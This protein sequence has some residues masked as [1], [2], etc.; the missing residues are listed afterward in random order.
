MTPGQPRIRG[1][2]CPHRK[3]GNFRDFQRGLMSDPATEIL[4]GFL[5]TR[6]IAQLEGVS[7]RTIRN[8]VVADKFPAPDA[9]RDGVPVWRRSTYLKYQAAVLAGESR[10]RD[11]RDNFLG[12]GRAPDQAA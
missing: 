1:L 9:I 2:A 12:G 4:D 8:R 10:G 11:R 6:R 5:E 7:S 3:A